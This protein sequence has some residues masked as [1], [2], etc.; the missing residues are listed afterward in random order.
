MIV[1]GTL[2]KV[3][4]NRDD[5]EWSKE[6]VEALRASGDKHP[7]ALTEF[8]SGRSLIS[9]PIHSC[10]VWYEDQDVDW[11]TLTGKQVTVVLHNLTVTPFVSIY[12]ATFVELLNIDDGPASVA[13]SRD[14]RRRL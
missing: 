9:F 13:Y 14:L 7:I 12:L 1:I 10:T 3:T 2:K 11:L 4:K 5:F 8:Q 6:A